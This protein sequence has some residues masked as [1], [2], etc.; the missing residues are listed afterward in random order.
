MLVVCLFVIIILI[1][2]YKTALDKVASLQFIDS[3]RINY[4]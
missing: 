1:L 4:Y 3:V 2:M